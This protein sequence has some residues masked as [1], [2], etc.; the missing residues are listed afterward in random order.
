MAADSDQLE[1]DQD[2]PGLV[3]IRAQQRILQVR[4]FTD[5]KLAWP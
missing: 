1:F 4:S 2:D 3:A 5:Q